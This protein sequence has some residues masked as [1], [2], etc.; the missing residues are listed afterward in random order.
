M[1]ARRDCQKVLLRRP[2]TGIAAW[3]AWLAN[4]HGRAPV[5]GAAARDP[6]EP[7]SRSAEPLL[8]T[9]T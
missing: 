4:T 3:L 9:P 8:V 5:R 1:V 2:F 6:P 7:D